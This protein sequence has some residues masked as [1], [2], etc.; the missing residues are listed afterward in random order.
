[1]KENGRRRKEKKGEQDERERNTALFR[2]ERKGIL[3]A[4]KQRSLWRL[5]TASMPVSST[6]LLMSSGLRGQEP[7]RILSVIASQLRVHSHVK[8]PGSF[9]SSAA[10]SLCRFSHPSFSASLMGFTLPVWWW[11][12]LLLQATTLALDRT[13]EARKSVAGFVGVPGVI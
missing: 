6:I 4:S 9:F 11:A 12:L 8:G 1:M 5:R 2:M 10:A 13:S 3:R 7:T